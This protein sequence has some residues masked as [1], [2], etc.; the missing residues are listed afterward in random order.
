MWDKHD[1]RERNA[2]AIEEH[3]EWIRAMLAHDRLHSEEAALKHLRRSKE[4]LLA[5]LKD[6]KRA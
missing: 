6:H 3:L 5:S 4:T 2:A 1:E